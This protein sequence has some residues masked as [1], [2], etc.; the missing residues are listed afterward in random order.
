MRIDGA[1]AALSTVLAL[2]LAAA[3]MLDR[4]PGGEALPAP[5]AAVGPFPGAEPPS[6]PAE[7]SALE[8]ITLPPPPAR[9]PVAAQR[10]NDDA[11]EPLAPNPP[12]ERPAPVAAVE[13]LRPAPRKAAQEPTP[14]PIEPLK[15][16]PEPPAPA[17]VALAGEADD[18]LWDEPAETAAPAE[19][20]VAAPSET[21]LGEGRVW[22]RILEHGSGPAIEIAWPAAPADREELF[23]RF[24]RCF[25]MRVALMD[26]EGRL[27]TR[28][29][30]PGRPSAVDLDRLSG[31]VR[32]PAGALAAA[33]RRQIADLSAYHRARSGLT[34]VRLF[35]RGVDAF[36]LGG[37]RHLI[38]EGYMD[39]QRLRARYRLAGTSVQVEAITV[40][41]RPVPG[42]ID[43]GQAARAACR[44]GTRRS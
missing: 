30:E 25:G 9:P 32:Q 1:S 6:A 41:A 15:P 37:L 34:P 19:A 36:L 18:G 20:A 31:F 17:Q 14:A 10:Q 4:A 40:D 42:R 3:I 2:V 43:L 27:Y 5:E 29:G 26:G 39:A 38:G 21:A 7:E 11:P 35:P 44:Q 33:E 28:E 23:R 12:P 16:A 22:L 8:P 24:D 13:P